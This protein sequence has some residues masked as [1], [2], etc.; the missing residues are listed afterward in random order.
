MRLGP[1][2]ATKGTEGC[3]EDMDPKTMILVLSSVGSTAT[4]KS[5]S[6]AGRASLLPKREALLGWAARSR[7]TDSMA[8]QTSLTVWAIKSFKGGVVIKNILSTIF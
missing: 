8:S 2:A 1:G 5:K 4:A 7:R 3:S 6:M